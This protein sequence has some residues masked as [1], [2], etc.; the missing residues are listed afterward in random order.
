MVAESD[1]SLALAL[2][3]ARIAE[4]KKAD[5][6]VVLDDGAVVGPDGGEELGEVQVPLGRNTIHEIGAF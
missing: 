4:D 1:D 6:I 2:L 5:D 3:A